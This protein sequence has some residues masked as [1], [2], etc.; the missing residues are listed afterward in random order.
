MREKLLVFTKRL[1]ERGIPYHLFTWLTPIEDH[2]PFT[3]LSTDGFPAWLMKFIP[4]RFKVKYLEMVTYRTAF[5]HAEKNGLPVFGLTVSSPW[6]LMLARW[7]LRFTTPYAQRIL[8]IGLHGAG[9]DMQIRKRVMFAL[10][11]AMKRNGVAGFTT[12][13]QN[14][15]FIKHQPLKSLPTRSCVIPEA[16]LYDASTPSSKDRA[17]ILF[18]AG[19]DNARRTP[20]KHLRETTLNRPFTKILLHEPSVPARDEE[21]I[22]ALESDATK[23]VVWTNDYIIGAELLAR[24]GGAK[25]CL[26]AYAPFFNATSSI[27]LQSICCGLPVL[28]SHFPD[29]TYLGE[30][31][32]KIGEFFEYSNPE[33]FKAAIDRLLKWT[34]ADWN[35]FAEARAKIINYCGYDRIVDQCLEL[36]GYPKPEGAEAATP[37]TVMASRTPR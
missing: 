18:I 20:I 8:Y 29:G 4:Q 14:E 27:A 19:G 23:E 37:T 5:S 28:I 26:V 21:T 36:I 17:P 1:R 32:G 13:F 24:F 22:K 25:Y 30:R 35:A 33:S 31:F 16:I 7:F 34:D 9:A 12:S 6:G 15:M 11:L 3:A 10:Q 2:A